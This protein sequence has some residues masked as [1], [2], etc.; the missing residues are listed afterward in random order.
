[1]DS[2]RWFI[3]VCDLYIEMHDRF[4]VDKKQKSLRLEYLIIVIKIKMLHWSACVVVSRIELHE[5]ET[6][7]SL[8]AKIPIY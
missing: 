8:A 4:S 6:D 3:H 5:T 2:I 1:M 7:G